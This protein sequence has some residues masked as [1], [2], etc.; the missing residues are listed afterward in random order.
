MDGTVTVFST[1]GHLLW[2][3]GVLASTADSGPI[4]TAFGIP[5]DAVTGRDWLEE[6]VD[7]D[8]GDGDWQASASIAAVRFPFVPPSTQRSTIPAE[9]FYV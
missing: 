4:A 8:R 3:A 2:N 7:D 5:E 9:L 1:A 6:L